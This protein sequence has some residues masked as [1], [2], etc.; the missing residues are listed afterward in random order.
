MNYSASTRTTT[1]RCALNQSHRHLNCRTK[2][3]TRQIGNIQKVKIVGVHTHSA[4]NYPS[5]PVKRKPKSTKLK[6]S[7]HKTN[8]TN[9]KTAQRRKKIIKPIQKTTTVN[10]GN[11]KVEPQPTQP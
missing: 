10:N 6:S 4:T 5:A 7:T 3:Y 1:W 8:K 2:A 11:L 9:K